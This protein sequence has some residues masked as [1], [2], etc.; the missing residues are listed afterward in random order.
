MELV[1]GVVNLG[2]TLTR[3]VMVP[4][5]DMITIQ[6]GTRLRRRCRCSY[7][8]VFHGRRWLPE[9]WTTSL[10][11]CTSKM[12]CG[13]AWDKPAALAGV[14]DGVVR[15]PVFVP[16]SLAVDDLLRRMQDDV[17]HMAIVVDEYGG[18]AGLVTIEDA[19]EEIVGELTDEH[20]QAEPEPE[21][22][23]AGGY[24]V[25]ARMS[26]TNSA[27]SSNSISR[28]MMLT[29]SLGCCPRPLDACRFPVPRRPRMVWCLPQTDLR[30]GAA[31]SVP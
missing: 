2:D 31:G 10:E 16:E 17:F 4:R 29:L 22:L 5:T 8:R 14:V 24:R 20:D 25:P 6:Q 11:F 28:M 15:E 30:G 9:T 18:V 19:L 23:A 13:R 27:H 12:R 7:D 3:E 26:S 1:R 21:A